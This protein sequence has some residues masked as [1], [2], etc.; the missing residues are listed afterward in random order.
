[1]TT[2]PTDRPAPPA[3]GAP[4]SRPPY[5]PPTLTPL[6]TVAARTAGPDGEK[7]LDALVGSD[8]GFLRD[9]EPTS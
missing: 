1:M 4:R 5:A 8:G 3:H 9:D 6:G 7:T 2:P